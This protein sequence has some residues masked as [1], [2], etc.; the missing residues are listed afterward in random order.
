[1]VTEDKHGLTMVLN[2]PS[3][4]YTLSIVSAHAK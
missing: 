4:T 2:P 1:L 3:S